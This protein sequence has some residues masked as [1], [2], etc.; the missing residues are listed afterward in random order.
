MSI[1]AEDNLVSVEICRALVKP[2]EPQI[3]LVF[4][5]DYK[6]VVI[7]IANVYDPLFVKLL[8][9]FFASLDSQ[10]PPLVF[11][12]LN[13]VDKLVQTQVLL[14]NEHV[15]TR[16]SSLRI[17]VFFRDFLDKACIRL[18]FNVMKALLQVQSVMNLCRA[19]ID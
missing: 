14:N 9:C 5:S 7:E 12:N 16:V 3:V 6:A 8:N 10:N 17:T 19:S 11:L 18:I 15:V 2:D 4:F 1:C 13:Y